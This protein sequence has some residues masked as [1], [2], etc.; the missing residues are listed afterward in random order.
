MVT[1]HMLRLAIAILLAA[2]VWAAAYPDPVEGD[3]LVKDF[4]F[5]TGETLPELRLHYTTIGS[6]S[7]HAV[8]IMHG[9][10]GSGHGFLSQTFAGELFGPG[11]LLDA[12]KYYIILTDAIGHGKS[13]KPSDGLHL[14]F[15]RYTYEDMVRAQYRLLTEKL[16]LHHVRLVMGTSMGA[17]HTW[18]WGYMFPD[19]MDALMPLASAPVEIGGRNRIL[20]K[21][22]MDAIRSDPEFKNG[23]YIGPLQGMLAAQFSLFIMTSSPLQLYRQNPTREQAD[24]AYQRRFHGDTPTLDPNDMLYAYDCSREYNPAPHLE[25]IVAPLYAIN[26]ADDQVNPPELGIVEREIKRVKRGRFILIPISDRTR[27]HGTHSMPTIWGEHLAELLKESVAV[28]LRDPEHPLW[29]SP[30]PET[31]RVEIETTKGSFTLEVTRALAPR[32]ADR[33]YHLVETG[34]YDNSRFY[35]VISGRFAQF[36]IPGDPAI[37]AIWRNRKLPDDPVRASNVRGTF[38]YAMTGPDTRT[39]QI[40][41]NTGDQS[42]QDSDGFAPFGKVVEGMEVV[43]RLYSDYGER[44]GGGMRAGHQA[45]LFEEGAA[46]LDRDFP[47]LDRLLSARIL[48]GEPQR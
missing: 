26:S 24:Q 44:S 32:G 48:E 41:I 5:S 3:Y 27:G 38:A 8:L 15:P 34:F 30:A 1:P 40:Y 45:R 36:G 22:I 42:R 47:K 46:Y 10:G 13:S 6:P 31:Y 35:R 4:K 7:G 29:R 19:F 17:M 20:R 33:F 12:T 39:T 28:A 16:A 21:L 9:T 37:A 2:P 18:M 43:D 25:K 11:Q 14:K 23:E